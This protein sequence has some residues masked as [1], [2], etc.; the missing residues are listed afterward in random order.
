ME[1]QWEIKKFCTFYGLELKTK[2][3][4]TKRFQHYHLVR[5]VFFF[6]RIELYILIN[7]INQYDFKIT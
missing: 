4:R 5:F 3:N 1:T 7:N 2:P 6:G